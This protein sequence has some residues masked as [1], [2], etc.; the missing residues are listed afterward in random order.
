MD[1]SADFHLDRHCMDMID[2]SS[3]II[4]KACAKNLL[5]DVFSRI[6]LLTAWYVS[7]K[8]N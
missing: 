6:D 2:I 5:D 7:K 1:Q 4:I 8:E 3:E